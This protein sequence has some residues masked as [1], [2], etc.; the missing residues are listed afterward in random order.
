MQLQQQITNTLSRS[1]CGGW[2]RGFL[3]SIL[4]QIAKGRS[5]SVKQKET[6][7]KVLARNT[8]ED[9]KS[10]VSWEA[11]YRA[12]Y[13][14]D[15]LVL[16][17]YH[18]RHNYYQ[19]M[20]ADILANNTPARSKFLRM[21]N[22]K[23]SKKVLAEYAK[24]PRYAKGAYIEPRAHFS[25]YKNAETLEPQ[26]WAAQNEALQK[27]K[28]QGGFIVAIEKYITSHA[29]SAKR[30]RVLPVGSPTIFRVE[31]RYIKLVKTKRSTL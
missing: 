8:E 24:E 29:K 30:Y 17:H 28:K 31:E 16:A 20:A 25:P 10:H 1:V 6:L 18:L 22:N 3:E 11:D 4:D 13:K 12:K 21:Y 27:F 23:Y 15:A 2:D 19:P 7:G 9:Q 14:T 5:L 26:S